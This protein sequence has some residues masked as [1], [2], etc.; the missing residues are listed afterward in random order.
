MRNGAYLCL[1]LRVMDR[2]Q[3]SSG[4]AAVAS[5]GGGGTRERPLTEQGPRNSGSNSQWHF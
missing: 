4:R 5:V 2:G 1:R 3:A